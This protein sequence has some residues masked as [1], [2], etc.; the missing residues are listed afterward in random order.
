MSIFVELFLAIDVITIP[1]PASE[2]KRKEVVVVIELR[3]SG[4]T[5]RPT[6]TCHSEFKPLLGLQDHKFQTITSNGDYCD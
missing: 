5:R 3:A 4:W 6:E 2:S 1:P